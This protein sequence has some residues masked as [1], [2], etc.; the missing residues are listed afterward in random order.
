MIEK[1]FAPQV[2]N[3]VFSLGHTNRGGFSDNCT[4]TEN[5]YK[6]I[7]KFF[8]LIKKITPISENGCRELWFCIDR[9]T[10]EDFGD[11]EEMYDMGDVENYED[12]VQQWRDNYPDEKKWYCVQAVQDEESGYKAVAVNHKFVIVIDPCA[13]KGYE[14]DIDSFANWLCEETE[15]CIDQ[16]ENKTYMDFVRKNLPSIHRTGTILQKH[17]W[18]MYPEEKKEFFEGITDKDVDDFIAFVT[19]QEKNNGK[20][21]GRLP[22]MTANDFYEFCSIGYTAMDYD[23]GEMTP[24]EQYYRFADGRDGELADIDGDSPEEFIKWLTCPNWHGAH[25]WEVCR[26]GNSTHIDLY[27]HHDAQGFYLGIAGSSYGRTTETIKFYLAL[28]RKEIPVF[29]DD[30]K[31]L[32]ERIM[33]TEKVGVVPQGI[34]PRYCHSSFP[35]EDVISFMN[36]PY[37]NTEKVAEKCIWQDVREVKLNLKED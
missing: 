9:G 20:V 19:Q 15:K 37:E 35:G 7:D 31:N 29:I 36:L 8:D 21:E 22:V 34:I 13:E 23:I 28:C 25:P 14:H 6:L 11:Y 3:F 18:D 24:K 27:V 26:G 33:G 12:F 16:L 2:D 32:L 4:F 1:I 17:L 10:I 5:S 30:G